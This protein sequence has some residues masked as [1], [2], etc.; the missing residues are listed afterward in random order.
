MPVP[1]KKVIGFLQRRI[2][3][4]GK[5]VCRI[6]PETKI[7]PAESSCG[8][9]QKKIRP[10]SYHGPWRQALP[11]ENQKQTRNTTCHQQ[12]PH[13]EAKQFIT[14]YKTK[15]KSTK[16]ANKPYQQSKDQ[17]KY[18]FHDSTIKSKKRRLYLPGILFSQLIKPNLDNYE[19]LI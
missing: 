9:I 2:H 15:Y 13:T 6:W 8:H 7:K 17:Q 5:E 18:Y 19:N 3:K 1:V 11:S 14:W 12:Q 4:C 10:D 16:E